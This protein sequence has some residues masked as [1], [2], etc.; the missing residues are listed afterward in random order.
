MV[1]LN[2]PKKKKGKNRE[3][4]KFV[5]VKSLVARKNRCKKNGTSK[6]RQKTGRIVGGEPAGTHE[7]PW[8][9]AVYRNKGWGFS[10]E[11]GGSILSNQ[12]A[13]SAAH[14]FYNCPENNC[15]KDHCPYRRSRLAKNKDYYL[16]FGLMD[17]S[18][19]NKK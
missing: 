4:Q 5:K 18:K 3:S 1:P 15:D 16:R 10:L 19:Q 11:C 2:L 6:G 9:V 12:W 7:F 13:V 8:Q 17:L 14:C